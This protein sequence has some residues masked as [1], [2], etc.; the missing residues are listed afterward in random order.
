M[1]QFFCSIVVATLLPLLLA[2]CDRSDQTASVPSATTSTAT[3]PRR[4]TLTTS[5]NVWCALALIADR[6][7]FFKDEDL[8]VEVQYQAAGRYCLDAVVS[9]SS[10]FGT[11]VEVNVAYHGFTGNEN[12]IVVGT[13]VR[14]TSSAIVARRSAGIREP[15]DLKGKSIALSPGTT[16]DIFAH[17][18]LEAHKLTA[19]DVDIR[20]IQP[21]ALQD[22]MTSKAIDA[23]STWD[24]FVHNIRHALGED[25]VVFTAAD[26]YAGYENI[27][28][29]RDWAKTHAS[30]IKSFL[31]ALRRAQQYLKA[32]TAEAQ[33]VIAQAINLDL[34]VVKANWQS[35]DFSLVLDK[36]QLVKAVQDEGEEIRRREE[37]F[38]DKP[39][40]RYGDFVDDSFIKGIE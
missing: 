12:V 33:Q 27:A 5:K 4:V 35:F 24:P 31:K 22:A 7:G 30:E 8:D 28:V 11:I 10:D 16:S 1:R 19:A 20:K 39:L 9:N 14:S 17:R 25:A 37:S 13:I 15:S 32:N 40:P 21:A 2:G 38:K 36:T 23:A 34:D 26:V 6:K 18:F 29:R 3:A